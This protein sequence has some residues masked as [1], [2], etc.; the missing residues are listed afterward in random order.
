MT[1]IPFTTPNLAGSQTEDFT[2]YEVFL[3]N[4][5]EVVTRIYTVAA[6]Q[7]LAAHEVVGL[8]GSGNIVPANN[9]TAPAIGFT[10]APLASGG[11][12]DETLAIYIGGH[13]NIDALV[14]GAAYDTE[15]KKLAAFDGADSPT[16]ILADIN[17]FNRKP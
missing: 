5:P 4:S 6:S 16:R 1:E 8:D 15:A 11:A 13:V 12:A 9:T 17:K 10:T 14:W 2:Q 7:T 3:S